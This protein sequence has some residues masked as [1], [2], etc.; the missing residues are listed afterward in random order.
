MIAVGEGL[1]G[2]GR[3]DSTEQLVAPHLSVIKFQIIL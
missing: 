1:D 3:P 2:T